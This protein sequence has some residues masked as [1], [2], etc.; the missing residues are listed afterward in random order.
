LAA[1]PMGP[2]LYPEDQLTDLPE[3]LLA[4]EVTREQLLCQLHDELPYEAAVLPEAW[5]ER[6]DGSVAI[7]QTIVVMKTQHRAMVLGNKGTRIKAIGQAARADMAEQFGR[8]VHLFLDV[9]VDE[10][11]QERGDYY[12]LFGL[13]NK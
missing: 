11:W 2:W 4:A 5:E 7:R 12:K 1:M 3:R 8:P 13:E 10:R 9:K 6:R